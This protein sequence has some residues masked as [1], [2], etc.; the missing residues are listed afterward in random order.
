M[1]IAFMTASSPF[2]VS[3]GVSGIGQLLT[4]FRILADVAVVFSAAVW[5]MLLVIHFN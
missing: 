4:S 1:L 5:G 2:L 3:G